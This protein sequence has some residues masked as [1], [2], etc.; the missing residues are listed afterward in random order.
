[1]AF[2]GATVQLLAAC[3]PSKSDCVQLQRWLLKNITAAVSCLLWLPAK[4]QQALKQ[5][6]INTRGVIISS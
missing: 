5:P 3:S 2:E 4:K 6:Y 1:M